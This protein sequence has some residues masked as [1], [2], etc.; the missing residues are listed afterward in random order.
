MRATLVLFSSAMM[1]IG[2]VP[3]VALAN[4]MPKPGQ[5][6][7][8][9]AFPG[10]LKVCHPMGTSPAG[11]VRLSGKWQFVLL[12]PFSA[13]RNLKATASPAIAV[14]HD[15]KPV[16]VERRLPYFENVQSAVVTPSPNGGYLVTLHAYKGGNAGNQYFT[17]AVHITSNG[18]III[19]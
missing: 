12:E 10:S 3:N 11:V 5:L 14:F 1:L 2:I 18:Q 16:S 8:N 19:P 17:M 13:W 15:G 9:R 6:L 7:C 4:T